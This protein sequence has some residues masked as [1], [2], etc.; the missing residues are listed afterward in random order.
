MWDTLDTED[1]DFRAA[2]RRE[3]ESVSTTAFWGSMYKAGSTSRRWTGDTRLAMN[4]VSGI[5][6]MHS[7]LGPIVL[8]LQTELVDDGRALC[9]TAAGRE[10]LDE[11]EGSWATMQEEIDGLVKAQK[12]A[13]QDNRVQLERSLEKQKADLDRNMKSIEATHDRFDANVKTI[14]EE[15]VPEYRQ[16]LEYVKAEVA[17]AKAGDATVVS[18]PSGERLAM[19]EHAQAEVASAMVGG[20]TLVSGSSRGRLAMGRRLLPLL[21]ALAGVGA[22]AGAIAAGAVTGAF[23]LIPSGVALIG[24]MGPKLVK[25]WKGNGDRDNKGAS[26]AAAAGPIAEIFEKGI[27]SFQ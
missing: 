4:I 27:S 5:M 12:R 11:M 13:L 8:Q 23:P 15:K 18:R 2:E 9:D 22:G 6:T 3:A 25:A 20:A 10:L 16:L 1:P 17:S 19:V 24:A 7:A 26:R 21:G 14:S